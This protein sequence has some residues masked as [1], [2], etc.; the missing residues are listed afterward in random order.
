MKTFIIFPTQLFDDTINIIDKYDKIIIIEEPHYF[1]SDEIKP[2]KIK[3]AYLRA[4]MRYYYDKLRILKDIIYIDY[5]NNI[6]YKK[7]FKNDELFSYH[8]ND[9]KLRNKLKNNGIYINEIED[10]PMFLMK[11]NDLDIYNK[12]K[13][14]SHATFYEMVK[15]KVGLLIGVKNQDIYNRSNPKSIIKFEH[16]ISNIDDDNY[17][18]EAINYTKKSQFKNNIG[19]IPTLDILK[20]YPISS[21]SSYNYFNYFLDNNLKNFGLFQDVIQDNNP[22][23]YHSIISPMLNIGI[24]T[25]NNLLYILKEY[26]DKVSLNTFEGYVRQLIGWREYMRY[27]Y[28]YKYDEL[29]KS[30]TFNNSKILDKSWYNG[31]TGISI[32]DNEINK[33]LKYGYSHHIVR[34]MIYLNFM[35]LNEIRPE[36]IYKW[37]M[38]V[39]CIDAYDWV[40]IP[41]IYSM[42]YFSKIGMRR[43]YLSSSNYII[44]MSNYKKDGKWDIIWNNKFREFVKSRKIYFYLRSIK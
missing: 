4:S 13:T 15:E 7:I 22:F 6:N 11:I 3:I 38:E 23:I 41:N 10:S 43:P 1:C 26:K 20:Y 5:K 18:K 36:D 42:G 19:S 44:R 34:L 2:N 8:L 35:I 33:S 21:K 14:P 28:L 29:I 30:N 37:F 32:I 12:R 17:Y 39:V 9:F 24:I 31:T 16:Y 40:M 27:L 25:P